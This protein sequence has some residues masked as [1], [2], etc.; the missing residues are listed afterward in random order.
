LEEQAKYDHKKDNE[1]SFKS[2]MDTARMENMFE[3]EKKIF[4]KVAAKMLSQ[5]KTEKDVAE[6]LDIPLDKVRDYV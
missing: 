1:Y 6:F 2:V 5:G 4:R 3:G